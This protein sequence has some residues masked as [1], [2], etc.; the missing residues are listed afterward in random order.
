[1]SLFIFFWTIS[2]CEN[3][4]WLAGCTKIGDGLDRTCRTSTLGPQVSEESGSRGGSREGL[5]PGDPSC[6][7]GPGVLPSTL[8]RA[9]G[10]H[11]KCPASAPHPG[12]GLC[13]VAV[14]NVPAK[15]TWRQN[16]CLRMKGHHVA[17]LTRQVLS[18]VPFAQVYAHLY[19]EGSCRETWTGPLVSR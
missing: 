8:P 3:H 7:G 14:I 11:L 16:P 12:P 10:A 1:M 5:S 17:E 18:P 19:Q 15:D 13:C 6:P 2:K 4:F 9:Q